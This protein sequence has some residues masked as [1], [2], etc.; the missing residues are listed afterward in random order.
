MREVLGIS[1]VNRISRFAYVREEAEEEF[2]PFDA[3]ARPPLSIL[4]VPLNSNKP[5]SVVTSNLGVGSVLAVG[6]SPQV[7][8]NVVKPVAV[9]VVDFHPVGDWTIVPFVHSSMQNFGA[10]PDSSSFR[11][12]CV[13]SRGEL[14]R[15]VVNLKS[16]IFST[17]KRPSANDAAITATSNQW[18]FEG[19]GG[20]LLGNHRRALVNAGV[21][22]GQGREGV[23]A[24]ARPDSFYEHGPLSTTL[25]EGR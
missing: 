4:G 20:T 10:T 14:P 19:V 2:F 11:T 1:M 22:V 24:L 17:D 25:M 6:H 5:G 16:K 21:V 12:Y 9:N 3:D 18:K 23:D 7:G 13:A 8:R 15:S